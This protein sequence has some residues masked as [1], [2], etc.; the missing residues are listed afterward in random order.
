MRPAQI[1][2]VVIAG[3]ASKQTFVPFDSNTAVDKLEV[4]VCIKCIKGWLQWSSCSK[5]FVWCLKKVISIFEQ[6]TVC[7]SWFKCISS[8]VEILKRKFEK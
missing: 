6:L 2:V 4:P 8:M 3:D 1:F 5:M 7:L